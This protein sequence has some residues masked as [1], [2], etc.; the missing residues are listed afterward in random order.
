V[1]PGRKPINQQ[2]IKLSQ[3][4]V[5]P[6]RSGVGLTYHRP[7][8]QNEFL[9]R[10]DTKI[11]PIGKN[12]RRSPETRARTMSRSSLMNRL[13]VDNSGIV[14][15]PIWMVGARESGCGLRTSL[16]RSWVLGIVRFDEYAHGISRVRI[17]IRVIRLASSAH[18]SI[19]V[20]DQGLDLTSMRLVSVL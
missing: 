5:N 14:Y 11:I 10:A 15:I 7:V 16:G 13:A 6:Q 9:F 4:A 17:T 18:K 19:L 8:C 1:S 3:D 12:S 2:S 20:T